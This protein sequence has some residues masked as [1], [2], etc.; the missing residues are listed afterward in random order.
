ML[1]VSDETKP[2]GQLTDCNRILIFPLE[3][4]VLPRKISA[5]LRTDSHSG[6]NTRNIRGFRKIL[7]INNLT[8]EDVFSLCNIHHFG[9]RY[10]LY[11]SAIWCFSAPEMGLIRLRNGQYQNA[12]RFISDYVIGY[13]PKLFGP[14]QALL[15]S[16]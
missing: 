5:Y 1:I 3:F 2:K 14:E 8:S 12:V 4:P 10:G 13:M 9:M 11:W 6:A 15:R 7:N 16:I